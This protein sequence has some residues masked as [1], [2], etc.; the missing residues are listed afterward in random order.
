MVVLPEPDGPTIAASWPGSMLKVMPD[1]VHSRGGISGSSAVSSS[2]T[3]GSSGAAVPNRGPT[4]PP[5]S[6]RGS[7]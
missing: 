3:S 4:R 2:S 6:S 5:L 7:G 1:S